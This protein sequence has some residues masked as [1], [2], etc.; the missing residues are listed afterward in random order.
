MLS[1][2]RFVAPVLRRTSAIR[3]GSISRRCLALESKLHSKVSSKR[4]L[5]LSL[6]VLILFFG[7]YYCNYLWRIVLYF[8]C[9]LFPFF[10]GGGRFLSSVRLQP[11]SFSTINRCQKGKF[12]S[13][14]SASMSFEQQERVEED[15]YMRAQ[16][17]AW[18]EKLRQLKAEEEHARSE[19]FTQEV[20]EPVMSDV[21]K[22]LEASGDKVS[23]EG[24]MTLAK[25]KLDL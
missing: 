17:E 7:F 13:N 6:L 19:A 22:M 8:P 16:E 18:K 11:I 4:C 10:W 14:H 1:A 25:W 2:S 23:D 9:V 24:L 12:S 5:F 3:V 15:R 20:L 21:S